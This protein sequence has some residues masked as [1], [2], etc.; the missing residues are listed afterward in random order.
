MGAFQYFEN[1]PNRNI[2]ND[3]N[4]RFIDLDGDGRPD[5]LITEDDLFQWYNAEGKKVLVLLIPCLKQ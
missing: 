5:L 3:P 1:F 4:A 2:S